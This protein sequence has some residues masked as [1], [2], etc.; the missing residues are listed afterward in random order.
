M[1]TYSHLNIYS[2]MDNKKGASCLI[3]PLDS[4][5]F[6]K[7]DPSNSEQGSLFQ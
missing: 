6:S 3:A 5:N 2:F 1:K 7:N 4:F